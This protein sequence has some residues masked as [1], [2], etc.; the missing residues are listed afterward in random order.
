[1]NNYTNNDTNDPNGFKEQ[2]KIKYEATKAIVGRFPNGTAT[3]MHLLSNAEPALDWDGYCTLPADG[4]LEWERRAD[5]LT[6]GMIYIM[7]SKNEI[8]K[9][10]LR[11]A[12]S[13]ENHTVYPTDIETAAWYLT[14][15]YPNIKSGNQK[16]KQ[17]KADGPKSV[18]KDN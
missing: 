4:R 13:Q 2:V 15:Q 1:M 17:K 9:K 14:T 8:A 5:A 11:L 6:Q 3:L 16:T 18:D 12:Y 7:N 10:D